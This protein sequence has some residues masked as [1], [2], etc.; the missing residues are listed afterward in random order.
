MTRLLNCARLAFYGSGAVL[1]VT[2][3]KMVGPIAWGIT[4]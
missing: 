2:V 3:F 4:L 1:F